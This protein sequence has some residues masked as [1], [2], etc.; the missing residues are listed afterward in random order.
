[1]LWQMPVGGRCRERGK[2]RKRIGANAQL[3][4]PRDMVVFVSLNEVIAHFPERK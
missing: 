3:F 4:H 1:M 2:Q